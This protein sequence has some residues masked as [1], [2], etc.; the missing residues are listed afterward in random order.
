MLFFLITLIFSIIGLVGF[1]NSNYTLTII[2]AV[3]YILENL[4][5]YFT[6][7]LKSL[8]T[9]FW[10][11]FIGFIIGKANNNIFPTICVALCYED[12]IMS[13]LSI[14]LLIFASKAV[15]KNNENKQWGI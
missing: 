15:D 3:L 10:A 14:P 1:Y 13:V 11:A 2:A 8:S 4:R 12:I 5:G 6:G 7:Q 9:I